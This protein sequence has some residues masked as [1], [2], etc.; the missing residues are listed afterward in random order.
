M[1]FGGENKSFFFSFNTEIK[2]NNG[3]HKKAVKELIDRDAVFYK[4]TLFRSYLHLPES[5]LETITPFSQEYLDYSVMLTE[6]LM[7][8]FSP[9]QKED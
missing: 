9:Y 8:L 7:L 2:A 3:N 4:K 1:A 6:H 5:I